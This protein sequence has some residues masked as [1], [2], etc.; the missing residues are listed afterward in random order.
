MSREHKKE[1]KPNLMTKI[2]TA[3]VDK[4]NLIFLL[5][6]IGVVFSCFSRNWVMVENTLSEYLPDESESSI[7]LDIMEDQFV[8]YGTAKVMAANISFREAERLGEE[9]ADLNGIQSVVF[10]DTQEHY[11]H[12]SALYTITFDYPQTDDRCLT[13]LEEVKAYLS[14]YDIYVSTDLG[15]EIAEIIDAEVQVIMVIVAIIVVIV[16]TFTTQTYAEVPVLLLTFLSAMVLNSGTNFLLGTISFVSNSVTSILQL[17]LSLD[18]AVILCN[19]F[20]EENKSLELREAVIAALSKAVPEIGAS[21]LTTIGGL[22]A[23][24]F[25]Q[26]KIGPDMAVCLIKAIFFSLLSV[27]LIMP[28]LLMIFGPLMKKTQHRNYVPKIPFAGKFAYQTQKIIPPIFLLVILAGFR[29]VRLSLCIRL[30]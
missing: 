25:M 3:I 4:R 11:N 14:G 29:F 13:A 8:T 21:S 17:A 28:G 5:L 18:Y 16:L 1:E 19:R 24:M 7:G 6:I 10:D 30:R 26:F 20:K 15:N 22:V 9:L 23:M 27:F 2:A 12:V